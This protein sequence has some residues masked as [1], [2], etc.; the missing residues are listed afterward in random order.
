MSAWEC[1]GGVLCANIPIVYKTVH[2]CIKATVSRIFSASH[3]SRRGSLWTGG[4]R[5]RSSAGPGIQ[6]TDDGSDRRS[7]IFPLDEISVF[8][9]IK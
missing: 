1:C 6:I 9:D 8:V 7:V 2:D 4:R 5:T 3:K